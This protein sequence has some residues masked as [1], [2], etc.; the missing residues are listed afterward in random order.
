MN[1]IDPAWE[2]RIASLWSAIDSY[3]P[4]VFVAEVNRLAAELPSDS[5]VAYF[6]RAAAEDSTGHPDLAVPLYRTALAIGLG[7][8]RR[9]RATI[10]MASSLRNLGNPKEAADL[11][12][13]EVGAASDELDGAVLAFLALVLA[14]LGREREALSHS[15][16]ALSRCLP[17]Y[18]RSL[19]RYA[20]ELMVSTRSEP[21]KNAP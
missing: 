4:E 6:E 14:D 1:N 20:A 3:E 10:Q 19:A 11:L 18:N 7:G 13:A 17:R 15:L 12:A 16:T 8:M 9:R 2:H 21:P 5:P